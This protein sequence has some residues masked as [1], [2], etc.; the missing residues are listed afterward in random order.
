MYHDW[1]DSQVYMIDL[2]VPN[3]VPVQVSTVASTNNTAPSISGDLVVWTRESL[4]ELFPGSGFFIAHRDLYANDLSDSG[5]GEF[6]ILETT[7]DPSGLQSSVHGDNV[8]YIV[9]DSTI[10]GPNNSRLMLQDINNPGTPAVQIDSSYA[11]GNAKINDDW[12]VYQRSVGPSLWQVYV[13]D[14]SNPT[15]SAHPLLV[16]PLDQHSSDLSGSIAFIRT[17]QYTNFTAILGFDLSDPSADPF[18]VVGNGYVH[19]DFI[20][21]SGNTFVYSQNGDI[22]LNHIV[23]EPT[24][25]V[26]LLA[27]MCVMGRGRR[28]C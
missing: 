3:P 11:L 12:I 22:Y 21:L 18:T 24:S 5:N 20:K 17:F 27:G 2:S 14:P 25:A 13:A 23:P 1:N 15:T 16:S 19:T 8:A 26:V 9:S 6:L 4:T 7:G 28:T 10:G